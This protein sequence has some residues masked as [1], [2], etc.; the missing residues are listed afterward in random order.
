MKLTSLKL[1][2][3]EAK[4]EGAIQ[5]IGPDEDK[6][7]RYPYG[8]RITLDTEALEKLGIDVSDYRAGQK[9]DVTAKCEVV[10]TSTRQ[11]QGGDDRQELELQITDLSIDWDKSDKKAKKRDAHL[12]EIGASAQTD[13]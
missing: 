10:G 4:T 12:D 9:C 8:T 3:K 1:T 6:G 7:P 13:S 11:R 5:A 2:P